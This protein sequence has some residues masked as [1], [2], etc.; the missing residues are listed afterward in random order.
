MQ[1]YSLDELEA[2]IRQG[3]R[4]DGTSVY[5][6]PSSRFSV[7]SDRDFTAI[8]SYMR[9]LPSQAEDPGRT[10]FGL[11]WR[12]RISPTSGPPRR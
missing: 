12:Y 7:M 1:T 2:I 3:I 11:L 8:I 6:M 5:L 10:R 9:Q 4:P